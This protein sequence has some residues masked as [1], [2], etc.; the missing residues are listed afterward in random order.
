MKIAL[1]HD[2][3]NQMGGA[4]NVLECLVDMFPDAPVYTTIYAP[5]LMPSA[6][7]QWPIRSTWLNHAPLIGRYHQPYLPFYPLAVQSMDIRGYDLILSNKS[8]FIHGLRHDPSQQKHICYC[9]APTRYVW[10]YDGYATREGFGRWLG[11][12]MSP[13]IQALRQWDYAAAQRVDRFVA[14]SCEIQQRIKRYYDR[15]SVIIYPPV[16]TDRF[17]PLPSSEK[18]D[19][20]YLIVS[21]LIPYKRIDL[22]VQ[23]CS[24]LGKRLIVVGDGRDR[25]PLEAMAGPTVQFTGRLPTEEVVSLMARCR[26]FFFPGFEDFG[27]APVEAQAAGRPVIAFARGGALDTVIEGLTG[28]FFYEQTVEAL[29]AAIKQFETIQFDSAIIRANAERFSETRFR[30]EILRVVEN[31]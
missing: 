29:V 20:Y 16:N 27:I 26:A 19:D 3:L 24:R 8:G 14:I 1:A 9:L 15:D 28:L 2:W 10:D 12:A 6:Y 13:L 23:A 31:L 17:Q 25:A 11:F 4:E 5:D 7:Q 21:R 18:P 22:A 30:Q